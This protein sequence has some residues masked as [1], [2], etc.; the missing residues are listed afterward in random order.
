M[1]YID[2]GN[3]VIDLEVGVDYGYKLLFV[4]LFVSLVVVGMF[5][6]E[7]FVFYFEYLIGV[8]VLVL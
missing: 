6:V 1:V 3:W 8:F 5:Y 4:V 7:F 2:L